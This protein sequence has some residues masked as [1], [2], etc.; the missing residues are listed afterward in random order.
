M[1]AF[2]FFLMFYFLGWGREEDFVFKSL[3]DKI[4]TSQIIL[5]TVIGEDYMC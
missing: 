4:S 2:F 5:S 1:Q 3:Y